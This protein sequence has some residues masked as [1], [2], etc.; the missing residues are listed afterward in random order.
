MEPKSRCWIAAHDRGTVV[1]LT[2]S[3]RIFN[4]LMWAWNH[5]KHRLLIL[6]LFTGSPTHPYLCTGMNMDKIKTENAQDVF[7]SKDVKWSVGQNQCFYQ[8]M[9]SRILWPNKPNRCFIWQRRASSA[10]TKMYTLE[11]GFHLS[12]SC[13][14]PD[15][16][17][18]SVVT[19]FFRQPWALAVGSAIS[20][21][22]VPLSLFH[23]LP[24][25]GGRGDLWCCAHTVF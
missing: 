2:R 23:S 13:T 14:Y 18:H 6:T 8:S 20:H 9:G 5:L 22:G 25:L 10:F 21:L 7:M 17:T 16:L 4:M 15:T 11:Y 1:K 24:S 12:P 19:L 3:S